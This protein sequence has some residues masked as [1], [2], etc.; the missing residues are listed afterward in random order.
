[1][2]SQIVQEEPND[3]SA[4]YIEQSRLN[5]GNKKFSLQNEKYDQ[6]EINIRKN[7]YAN[8]AKKADVKVQ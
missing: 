7:K 5:T 4:N 8:L 1:M 3:K 6:T 2:I